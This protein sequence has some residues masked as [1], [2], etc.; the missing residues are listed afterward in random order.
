MRERGLGTN[1]ATTVLLRVVLLRVSELYIPLLENPN[2]V[3][4][5][6]SYC[7]IPI[8]LIIAKW[9]RCVG[10]PKHKS[11]YFSLSTKQTTARLKSKASLAECVPKT[12]QAV[13]KV[14]VEPVGSPKEVLNT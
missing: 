9:R 2:P 14:D 8:T 3:S 5:H 13:E 6:I 11:Y 1:T 12:V 4:P 7:P 10:A